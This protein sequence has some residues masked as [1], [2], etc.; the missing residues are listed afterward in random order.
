MQLPSVVDKHR[1]LVQAP[2]S[3]GDLLV[4]EVVSPSQVQSVPM[5]MTTVMHHA[6]T[7]LV[8]DQKLGRATC[9]E[10]GLYGEI[11][12][13]VNVTTEWGKVTCKRCL[14]GVQ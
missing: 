5:A 8:Q 13:A 7:Q 12:W 3:M 11:R 14:K 4:V 1:V 6:K 9:G 10:S 2:D